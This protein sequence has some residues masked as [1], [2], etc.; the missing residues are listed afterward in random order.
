MVGLSIVA[1]VL[2]GALIANAAVVVTAAPVPTACPAKAPGDPGYSGLVLSEV[3]LVPFTPDHA[4]LCRYSGLNSGIES[5]VGSLAAT[6]RLTADRAAL[7]AASAN[8]SAHL[9]PV[10]AVAC[11]AEV[12]SSLD[13]YFWNA[14]HRIRVRFYTSG[15]TSADNGGLIQPS[16][17]Q[18]DIV[19]ALEL[20]TPG[21]EPA[22]I[23]G[24]IVQ[25]GGPVEADGS[26]SPPRP[27]AGLVAVYHRHAG[28]TTVSGDPMARVRTS[29]D[30][31][32]TFTVAP[33]TYFVVAESLDG[34][35][36]AAP[37]AI[38]VLPGGSPNLTLAVNVP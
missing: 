9:P 7:I 4:L 12:S 35:Q 20:L 22:T 21:H 23:R 19:P 27:I 3:R 37:Q 18:G 14:A 26:S 11:P 5:P 25:F 31:A 28:Q 8:A 17:A 32:Y 6:A 10:G 34:A 2:G 24:T 15:C 1:A 13:V 38:T 33:G 16:V 29:A 36:L 30:G